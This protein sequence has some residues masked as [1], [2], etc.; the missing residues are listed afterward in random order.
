YSSNLTIYFRENEEG[1]KGEGGESNP[2]KLIGENGDEIV[3]EVNGLDEDVSQG[4]YVTCVFFSE[5][6]EESIDDI[7]LEEGPLEIHG[8]VQSAGSQTVNA[9]QDQ[10]LRIINE[11]FH[12]SADL[13]EELP[14]EIYLF[15][16]EYVVVDEACLGTQQPEPELEFEDGCLE[17]S[18][19][20]LEQEK[21]EGEM[22]NK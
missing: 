17:E 8:E 4:I 18:D 21:E 3:D 19:D 22:D 16:G 1:F 13:F 6:F 7:V 12:P 15:D 5:G 14:S 10:H 20:H 2:V 9:Q 11:Q